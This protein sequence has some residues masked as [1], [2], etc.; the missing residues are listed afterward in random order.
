MDTIELQCIIHA[1]KQERHQVADILVAQLAYQGFN[2]FLENEEGLKAYIPESDFNFES[3]KNLADVLMYKDLIEFSY[4]LIKE[5]NW[6]KSWEKSFEPVVI[7]NQCIVRAP[8]H[9]PPEKY[10]YDIVIEP[11]MSFGTGH[12]TTTFLM[13]KALLDISTANKIV[14]DMG[15]GTGLLSILADKK[16]AVEVWAIDNNEW[17]YKNTLEN[18]KINN[19]NKVKAL[20]GDKNSIQDKKFN[21]ILANINKNVLLNDIPEYAEALLPGGILLLSG[22]YKKDIEDIEKKAAAAGLTFKSYD[23][24]NEW[25]AI[26]YLR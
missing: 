11:K 22:I 19:S 6:N 8:F 15:C 1:A 17:A 26:R 23:E 24:H 10:K 7:G 18:I 4:K 16:N 20:Q 13:I 9:N 5:K 3:V 14:L 2:S 21:V 12:H 25:V